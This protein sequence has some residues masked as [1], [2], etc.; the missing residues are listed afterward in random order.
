MFTILI[1]V[2]AVVLLPILTTVAG[3]VRKYFERTAKIQWSLMVCVYCVSHVP[4]ILNRS[5]PGYEH[6]NGTLVLFLILVV[7]LSDVFQFIWGK[8]CGKRK[9]LP[10]ISPNKYP[11][12]SNGIFSHKD[13]TDCV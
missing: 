1:P 3:E 7:E 4:A 11:D 13:T 9:I 12:K 2:Y 6:R 8:C 5:I 10:G